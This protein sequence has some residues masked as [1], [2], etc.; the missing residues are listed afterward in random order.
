MR[1]EDLWQPYQPA[2]FPTDGVYSPRAP[3]GWH[4]AN[5]EPPS[6][7]LSFPEN[8][9]PPPGGTVSDA[10]AEPDLGTA[11]NIETVDT[12]D[13]S[14]QQ[15][16]RQPPPTATLFESP[17]GGGQGQWSW[18]DGSATDFSNWAPGMPVLDNGRKGCVWVY[19]GD[20]TG[21]LRGR[22][23]EDV[24]EMSEAVTEALGTFALKANQQAFRQ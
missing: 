13:W 2:R 12:W 3:Q 15:Q 22:L 23:S 18:Q 14:A 9:N 5:T 10:A 6:A 7:A 1:L 8:V 20:V 21:K 16:R 4:A 24:E 17:I 11:S 19:E